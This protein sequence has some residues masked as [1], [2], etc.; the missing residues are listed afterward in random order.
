MRYFREG[1][2]TNSS[3]GHTRSKSVGSEQRQERRGL[4]VFSANGHTHHVSRD[5]SLP[6]WSANSHLFLIVP[7]RR[8]V[9]VACSGRDV[10]GPDV[11]IFVDGASRDSD[12]FL[13]S[14]GRPSCYPVHRLQRKEPAWHAS[15]ITDYDQLFRTFVRTFVHLFFPLNFLDTRCRI[16]LEVSVISGDDSG[17][18]SGGGSSAGW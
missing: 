9:V 16:E 6:C 14:P 2:N 3:T 8:Y 13:V 18:G 11:S 5:R 10:A 4:I 17:S 12:D 7:G 1:S 15:V